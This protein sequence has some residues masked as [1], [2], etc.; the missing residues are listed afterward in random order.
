MPKG[1]LKKVTKSD[2]EGGGCNHEGDATYSNFSWFISSIVQFLHLLCL[3][4]F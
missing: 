1:S 3:M 4:E 2:M